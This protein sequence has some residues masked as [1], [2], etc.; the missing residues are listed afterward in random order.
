M[1]T[2]NNVS[3]QQF[4]DTERLEPSVQPPPLESA[5]TRSCETKEFI[6]DMIH[7]LNTHQ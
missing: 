6:E 4:T 7:N 3:A 5:E 1:D 2:A